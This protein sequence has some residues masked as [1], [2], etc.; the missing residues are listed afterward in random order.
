M[1]R[2]CGA[3]AELERT[4]GLIEDVQK[5]LQKKVVHD[6]GRLVGI[7]DNLE[8]NSRPGPD[9]GTSGTWRRFVD[10]HQAYLEMRFK[11]ESV[12]AHYAAQSEY[13]KRA[14]IVQRFAMEDVF[15]RLTMELLRKIIGP[16]EV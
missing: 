2:L 1:I 12:F 4:N 13:Y 6:A 8:R 10:K 3:Q 14:N 9:F 11:I 15:Y 5:T 16:F 7:P